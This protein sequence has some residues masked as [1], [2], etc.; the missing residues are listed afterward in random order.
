MRCPQCGAETPD[1][2]WNCASC[3][4]NLYWAS[5]HYQELT[6]IR[7]QQGLASRPGTPPFLIA[8]HAR[9]MT[10]RTS[11]GLQVMNKVRAIARRV[12]LGETAEQP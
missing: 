2:Q 4:I 12:M 10:E 6:G 7:Q 3:R 5:Q 11:R 1:D 8:S 9:E